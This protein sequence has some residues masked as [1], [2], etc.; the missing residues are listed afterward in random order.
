M[1]IIA[2]LVACA[3]PEPE[4]A[5]P[6]EPVPEVLAE[7]VPVTEP[8]PVAEE[9]VSPPFVVDPSS[10]AVL[11]LSDKAEALFADKAF[12]VTAVLLNSED[13]GKDG[14]RSCA[15]LMPA[16][17]GLT[18]ATPSTFLTENDKTCAEDPDGFVKKVFVAAPEQMAF[19]P[20]E[21]NGEKLEV[22]SVTTVTPGAP[23]SEPVVADGIK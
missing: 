20:F 22:M 18:D 13:R 7:V 16:Q 9:V 5:A 4:A 14:W 1:L 6:T 8:S 10:P 3:T 19:L 15:Q 17:F 11:A 2:L 12:I 21:M 23:S